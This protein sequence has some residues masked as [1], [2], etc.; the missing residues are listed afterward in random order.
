M[1]RERSGQKIGLKAHLSAVKEQSN[2]VN[3]KRI[4]VSKLMD[5]ENNFLSP[6]Y[7]TSLHFDDKK[8][9]IIIAVSLGAPVCGLKST[10]AARWS[11]SLTTDQCLLCS[12]ST[13]LHKTKC[14][15]ALVIMVRP[16]QKQALAVS[17]FWN[18]LLI[19]SVVFK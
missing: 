9:R 19:H 8:V 15:S 10:E 11:I 14:L 12:L 4:L 2:H 3:R 1:F 7:S 13:L 16:E 18:K 5:Q 17:R 6:L